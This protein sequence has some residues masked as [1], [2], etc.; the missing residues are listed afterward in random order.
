MIISLLPK[1]FI[2]KEK[3]MKVLKL[4]PTFF[5]NQ[6][7]IFYFMVKFNDIREGVGQMRLE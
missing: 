4:F 5:K 7:H 3:K 1:F 2:I 6:C